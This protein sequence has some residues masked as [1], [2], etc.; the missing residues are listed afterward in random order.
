VPSLRLSQAAHTSIWLENGSGVRA[1]VPTGIKMENA[2]DNAES[3][4]NLGESKDVGKNVPKATPAFQDIDQSPVQLGSLPPGARVFPLPAGR[5]VPFRGFDWP[6]QA[7]ADRARITAWSQ[8]YGACNW[9]MVMP[10]GYVCVDLDKRPEKDG[11][12]TLEQF[13]GYTQRGHDHVDRYNAFGR[14]LCL[15][16]DSRKVSFEDDADMLRHATGYKLANDGHD[17]RSILHYLG[18][19]NVQHTVRY[20]ELAPTRFKDF[21]KD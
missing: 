4:S 16:S 21:W 14:D 8:E 3:L 6:T 18:H 2:K 12:K 1:S 9:A 7:T 13:P 11:Y 20:T 15:L 10:E 19:R 17:T 5:K